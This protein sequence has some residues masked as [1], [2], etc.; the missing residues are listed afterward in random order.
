[1]GIKDE[2]NAYNGGSLKNLIF[3]VESQ[4][5]NVQGGLSKNG[6]LGQFADLR[7]GLAKKLRWCF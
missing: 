5:N 6:W 3:S 1:M 2:K 7:G 4:K